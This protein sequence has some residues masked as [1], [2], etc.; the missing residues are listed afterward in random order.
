M[1]LLYV[2]GNQIF[3]ITTYGGKEVVHR[4]YCSIIFSYI[5]EQR[6]INYNRQVMNQNRIHV[7][8]IFFTSKAKNKN[9]KNILKIQPVL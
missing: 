3:F 4:H 1:Y 8:P 6:E 9:V 5:L 7:N 2:D